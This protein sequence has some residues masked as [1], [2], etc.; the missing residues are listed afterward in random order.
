VSYK[1]SELSSTNPDKTQD[2]Q[3]FISVSKLHKILLVLGIDT[4]TT[5]EVDQLIQF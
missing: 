1:F 5:V 2:T 3:D 4:K